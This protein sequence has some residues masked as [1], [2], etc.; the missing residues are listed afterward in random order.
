MPTG[1]EERER[2][3]DRHLGL[4]RCCNARSVVGFMC[5]QLL[6]AAIVCLPRAGAFTDLIADFIGSVVHHPAACLIHASCGQETSLIIPPLIK[7]RSSLVVPSHKLLRTHHLAIARAKAGLIMQMHASCLYCTV[8]Y[9]IIHILLPVRRA[10]D[11]NH[12]SHATEA[13]VV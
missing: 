8:L 6:F 3:H 2:A 10:S 4:A 11:A 5:H 1:D 9:C 13:S 7:R 12:R